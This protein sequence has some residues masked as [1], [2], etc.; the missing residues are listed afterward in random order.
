MSLEHL[1]SF[2]CLNCLEPGLVSNRFEELNAKALEFGRIY[3]PRRPV[4][5]SPN[6]QTLYEEPGLGRYSMEV[7]LKNRCGRGDENSE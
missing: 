6:L 7:E 3:E 1:K 2:W 4:A 5:A